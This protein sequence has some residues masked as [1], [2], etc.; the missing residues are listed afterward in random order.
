MDDESY[1]PR[2][3]VKFCRTKSDH[4]LKEHETQNTDIKGISIHVFICILS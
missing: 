1:I 4:I 2:N 3:D